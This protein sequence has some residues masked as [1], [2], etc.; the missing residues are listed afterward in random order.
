ME[1]NELTFNKVD[2]SKKYHM[3]GLEGKRAGNYEILEQIQKKW[4]TCVASLSDESANVAH[5]VAFSK[6]NLS[7]EFQNEMGIVDEGYFTFANMMNSPLLLYRL[8]SIFFAPPITENWYKAIWEYPIQHKETGKEMIFGEHKGAPK[9]WL[10]E[11]NPKQLNEVFKNDL[12]ELLNFLVSD[13]IPHP[14]DRCT[15]GQIA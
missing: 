12:L 11:S 10:S 9:F 6:E 4:K 2:F 8:I 13:Q 5:Q 15:S 14:Y 1:L 3:V 7:F